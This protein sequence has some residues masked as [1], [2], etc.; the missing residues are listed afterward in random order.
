MLS[1]LQGRLTWKTLH[2]RSALLYSPCGMHSL[3]CLLGQ[4][5]CLPQVVRGR[6]ERASFPHPCHCTT[7]EGAGFSSPAL[8]PTALAHLRPQNRVNS[9]ASP[10]HPQLQPTREWAL[11]PSWAAEKYLNPFELRAAF[12]NNN[13]KQQ[14]NKTKK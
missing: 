11:H 9:S 2:H 3:T 13:S 14:Q 1:V 5:F 6:G 4:F 12:C 7:D 10:D 8:R